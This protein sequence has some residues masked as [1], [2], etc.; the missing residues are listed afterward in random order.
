VRL[1]L[2]ES[3]NAEDPRQTFLMAF[4]H[5]AISLCSGGLLPPSP[6]AEKATACQDQAG[7]IGYAKLRLP[8]SKSVLVVK[9]QHACKLV[10]DRWEWD[11][12][13]S[14]DELTTASRQGQKTAA[15]QD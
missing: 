3:A 12:N 10:G 9:S 4:D 15:S 5:S 6:P 13:L 1:P 8:Q 2:H 14:G 11:P 7:Q